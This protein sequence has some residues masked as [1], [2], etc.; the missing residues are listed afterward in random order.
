MTKH[1]HPLP[2]AR[3]SQLITQE[4]A[5]ELIVYDRQSDRAY[6]LNSTAAF[7]WKHCDGNTSVAGMASL[8][9]AE[10]KAPVEH[11]IVIYALDQLNKS[12]LLDASYAM[13]APK[14][15]LSRRAIVRQG[16]AVAVAIPFISAITAPTAAQA[17][18]CL[19]AGAVCSSDAACCSNT[20][21]DNGRG[22]FECT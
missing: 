15:G 12:E 17:A 22:G 6:C 21:A 10:V 14:P 16:V 19:P 13:N 20:C 1:E 2:L 3:K 11:E 9:E 4:V 18:T 8:L 5:D 7:V